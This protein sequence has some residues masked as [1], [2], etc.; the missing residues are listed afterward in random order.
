MYSSTFKLILAALCFFSYFGYIFAAPVVEVVKVIQVRQ[1]DENGDD[2]NGSI[3][4]PLRIGL[5]ST[6]G[7]WTFTLRLRLIYVHT[8][9]DYTSHFQ[10]DQVPTW[11]TIKPTPA[12]TL[13][14]YQLYATGNPKPT[15]VPAAAQ[16]GGQ[17]TTFNVDH[18][19][20]LQVVVRWIN[21]ENPNP[22][23]LPVSLAVSIAGRS[24]AC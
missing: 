6:L 14:S 24:S 17:G 22:Y 10:Y 11:Y 9:Y 2:E 4:T 5:F 8:A 3:A 16:A 13:G 19:L 18:V 12:S 1:D 21:A 20:E 7:H 23:V 15:A